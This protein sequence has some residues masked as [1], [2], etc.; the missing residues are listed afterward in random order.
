MSTQ[1]TV[2]HTQDRAPAGGITIDGKRYKGG[3]FLPRNWHFEAPPLTFANNL[4]LK[5]WEAVKNPVSWY[6]GIIGFAAA[7]ITFAG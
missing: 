6:M 7:T 2:L 4:E 1:E 3:A 5:F